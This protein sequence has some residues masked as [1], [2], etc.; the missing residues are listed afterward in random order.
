MLMM[1]MLMMLM[2]MLM[3]MQPVRGDKADREESSQVAD[4]QNLQQA[5][6]AED[7]ADSLESK[8]VAS[9]TLQLPTII[10][11]FLKIES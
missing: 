10:R 2:M 6:F 5:A 3:L 4:T 9:N 7:D 8:M 1:M 11:V